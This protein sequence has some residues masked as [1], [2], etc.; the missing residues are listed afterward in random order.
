MAGL[1]RKPVRKQGAVRKA[2]AKLES[3]VMAA[4]GRRAVRGAARKVKGVARKA[5]KAALIA[6]SLAAAKVVLDEVRERRRKRSL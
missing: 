1:T 5:A 2:Y 6:G 4:A 3:K